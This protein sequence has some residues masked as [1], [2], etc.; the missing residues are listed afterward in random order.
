MIISKKVLLILTCFCLYF[1]TIYFT[2]CSSLSIANFEYVIPCWDSFNLQTRFLY[3]MQHLA[4]IML[5]Q[6]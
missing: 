5:N 3:E 2:P 4:E 6:C 1:P